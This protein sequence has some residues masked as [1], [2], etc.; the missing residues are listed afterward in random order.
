MKPRAIATLLTALLLAPLAVLQAA[1]KPNIIVVLSDDVGLSRISCYGAAPFQTPN[2]DKL[3]ATGLRFERC[4]SMPLCGP[5]R[6]VLLTGQYPFRTGYLGNNSSVIDPKRHPT[7]ANVMQQAGYATC[8]IGKLGQSAPEG[9]A[10]AP[11]A[12]GFDEYMLW[13]GRNTPDRY[14]N[15]RYCRNGEFVQ[16]QPEQYGPDLTHEFLVDFMQRHREKPFFVYYSAVLAHTPF[17]RTPATKPG[18]KDRAQ[19][20]IDMVHY[21]DKQMG[22]LVA[23]LEKLGLRDNTI[24]LFTSD[25]G[26]FGDPIGTIRGRPVGGIKGDVTEGGVREPLI[27]NCP[28]L[29]P[30][31]RVCAD[32]TDFTD[33][34]PTVLE[35]TGVSPPSNLKL[36]GRSIAPQI[37]G[38][39]G[40]ARVWVYAQLAGDY[41]IA[42]HQFKLYGDGKFTDISD[43]PAAEKAVSETD[44]AALKAKQRLAKALADLRA[45]APEFVPGKSVALKP[46]PAPA[47]IKQLMPED[48][49]ADLRLL[50]EQKIITDINTWSGKPNLAGA[51]VAAMMIRAASQFTPVTTTEQAIT[52]LQR[53]G[54]INSAAYWKE[55]ATVGQTCNATSTTRLIQKLAKRLRTR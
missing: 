33:L 20:L 43:S 27:V 29:V 44:D 54:I 39:D 18:T 24:I 35:L 34:F 30:G 19:I 48:Y 13:M 41:F 16:G 45:G 2:L 28:A 7:I 21:L 14:W 25:N 9:D 51:Q 11:R 12:M 10:Q 5:S 47:N 26:P 31:G 23:D 3:A 53:E 50:Q 8:A 55:H 46:K 38:R 6:G 49:R 40:K 17:M 22:R 42:D 37:L 4:Y 36:D 15:P 32:L 1:G 52:V